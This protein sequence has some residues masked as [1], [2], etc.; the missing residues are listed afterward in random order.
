VQSLQRI[1]A[2]RIQVDHPMQVENQ[3]LGRQ[4]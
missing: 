1:E 4:S 2:G 3:Y